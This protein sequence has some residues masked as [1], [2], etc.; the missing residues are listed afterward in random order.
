[1]VVTPTKYRSVTYAAFFGASAIAH[2]F[3][4]ERS[5]EGGFGPEPSAPEDGSTMNLWPAKSSEN[6]TFDNSFIDVR[7]GWNGRRFSARQEPCRASTYA[8]THDRVDG[9]E[10]ASG[11]TRRARRPQLAGP[12][13]GV[14][15][16][17]DGGTAT[18]RLSHDPAVPGALQ[19][20]GRLPAGLVPRARRRRRALCRA[21][22]RSGRPAPQPVPGP[23]QGTCG[24]GRARHHLDR[25]RVRR[26]A[27]GGHRRPHL[28]RRAGEA[29]IALGRGLCLR[30]APRPARG[31]A[32][33]RGP[34][35]LTSG[36][37]H[38]TKDVAVPL[39]SALSRVGT[40]RRTGHP[41]R[42][43]SSCR[44]WVATT[45]ADA[46]SRRAIVRAST[47]AAERW[48]VG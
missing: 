48:F 4:D 12:A 40:S 15:G 39:R 14:A 31:A 35:G 7:R 22:P 46:A 18:G 2:P 24:D 19:Q 13:A 20:V 38:S 5:F 44:S 32:P 3:V 42:S 43:A 45:S 41:A 37:D 6:A 25:A 23:G 16:Q 30:A 9:W 28:R 47:R 34:P 36:R 27:A 26:P 1:M 29:G 8:G 10:R 33:H 11:V 21:D 17:P